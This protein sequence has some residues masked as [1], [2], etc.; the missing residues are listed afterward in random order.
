M[1]QRL[2]RHTTLILIAAIFVVNFFIAPKLR[3]YR[4]RMSFGGEE[5]T[6]IVAIRR[7]IDVEKLEIVELIISHI[8]AS[9]VSIIYE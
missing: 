5:E 3:E 2:W 7:I 4:K 9:H 8:H 6:M 1:E